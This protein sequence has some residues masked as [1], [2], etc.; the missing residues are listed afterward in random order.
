[1]NPVEEILSDK[2]KFKSEKWI[3]QIYPDFH[4]FIFLKYSIDIPWKEKL[5]LY[6]NK[7]DTPPI[8]CCGSKLKFRSISLGYR[9]YCSVKCLS[10]DE[11]IKAKRTKTNIDKYGFEN[12][13]QNT[14]VKSKL[15]SVVFEKYGVDNISKLEIT[16]KKIKDFNLERYGV[17]HNSQREDIK[18]KLKS[19]MI[20]NSSDLNNIKKQSI[21]DDIKRKINKFDI[22]FVEYITTSNYKLV[23]NIGHEFDIHKNMLNDRIRN[24]NIICTVCNS[25]DGSSDSERQLADFIISKYKGTIIRNDRMLIGSEVDI[26]LPDINLAFEFN[27]VYWH[28]DAYKDNNYHNNKS[29]LL[30][31]KG[32]QL[33]HIWEDDWKIKND[34]VKSRIAN[35]LGESEKIW[36]RRCVIKIVNNTDANLFLN[37]NH[38]QGRC[39]SKVK[40]GLYHNEDLV[41]LMTFGNLRK[42]L[43]YKASEGSYELLRFCNKLNTSVVGGASKLFKYFIKNYKPINII[44]YADRCWSNGNLYRRLGFSLE[45]TTQPNYYYVVNG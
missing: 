32:I 6:I 5:F 28:S 16:K 13:M 21:I 12:P 36:A 7:M 39:N 43:G 27:G 37:N 26:Y 11:L 41:S 10:N 35:L 38:I 20:K 34:I 14:L 42:S 29:N 25:I 33:I 1:M 8:C 23:C 3:N 24:K 45:S 4:S 2:N 19:Y 17:E 40:I 9:K 15:S 22:K 31:E 30:F 18:F 44:S